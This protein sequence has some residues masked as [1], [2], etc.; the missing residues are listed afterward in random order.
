MVP[1]YEVKLLMNPT[2]VLGS[3]NKLKATVLSTF[4]MPT[5]VTKMNVQFLD[6]DA[7]DIYNVG[8]SPR[9]RK[10][11]GGSDFELTYKKRYTVSNGDID[12]ALSTANGEGFDSTTTTYDAQIEWGYQKQTLSISRDKTASDSGYSGKIG[13]AHV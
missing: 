10:M 8:W 11:E 3:D 9:I 4:A 5:S 12:G 6:T 13:R 7:K 2:V 1:D